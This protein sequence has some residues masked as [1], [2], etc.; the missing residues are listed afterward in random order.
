MCLDSCARATLSNLQGS[1]WSIYQFTGEPKLPAQVASPHDFVFYYGSTNSKGSSQEKQS[2]LGSNSLI[3]ASLKF[4]S[5]LMWK[6]CVLRHIL[7]TNFPIMLPQWLYKFCLF[8]MTS[9]NTAVLGYNPQDT[10]AL[11]NEGLLSQRESN[12]IN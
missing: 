10:V 8:K 3:Y 2:P 9:R 7:Y 1:L 6:E 12:K 5:Q 4:L 11:I